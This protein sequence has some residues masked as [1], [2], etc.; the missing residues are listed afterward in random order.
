MYDNSS[1][2]IIIIPPPLFNL[3]SA[4]ENVRKI[5]DLELSSR[6]ERGK[7]EMVDVIDTYKRQKGDTGSIEVQ[8]ELAALESGA[9]S[10]PDRDFR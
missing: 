5:F 3:C 10:T 8:G 7:Q 2:N 9:H 1:S 6:R 4:D